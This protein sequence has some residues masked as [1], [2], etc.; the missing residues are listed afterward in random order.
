MN[1]KKNIIRIAMATVLILLVPLAAMQFT[2]EVDWSLFDFIFAG[3]LLFGTGLAFVLIARRVNL[4]TYRAAV[5]VAVAAGLIL[6]WVNG[7]VGI[8]GSENNPANLL[9][10]G[11]LAVG[12]VGAVVARL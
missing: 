8:I 9:Y 6:I 3:G 5:G 10:A 12:L 2:D 1:V 4:P 7:A 11:V